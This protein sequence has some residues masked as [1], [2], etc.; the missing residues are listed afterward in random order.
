MERGTF[1]A[2]SM[3]QDKLE[4]VSGM[5]GAGAAALTAEL[6]TGDYALS[7]RDN[8][9]SS[10][11]QTSTGLFVVTLKECPPTILD[12][13]VTIHTAAGTALSGEVRGW[14]TST[15][16]ITIAIMDDEGAVADPATTDHIRLTVIGRESTV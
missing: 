2:K 1:F 10:C 6:T 9:F 5:L 13:Y 11:E 15:K 16:K 12:A 3:H 7:A 14:V 8:F 4:L